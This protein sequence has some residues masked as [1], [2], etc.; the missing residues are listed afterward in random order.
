[1][2]YLVA[3][4]VASTAGQAISGKRQGEAQKEADTISKYYDLIEIEEQ[5]QANNITKYNE[6]RALASGESGQIA[7]SAGQNKRGNSASLLNMQ[8]IARE[9]ME[10]NFERMD[11]SIATSRDM[12]KLSDSARQS[13]TESAGE[14]R[15]LN[16]ATSVVRSGLLLTGKK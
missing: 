4:I 16:L 5:A 11:D 9:D 6:T 12:A 8:S 13:A 14:T 2:S 10:L 1:M 3:S 15:K 7:V